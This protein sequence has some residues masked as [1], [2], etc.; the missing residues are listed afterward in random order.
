M[1]TKIKGFTLLELLVVIAIL[2]LLATMVVASTSNSRTQ[3][4]IEATRAQL[5]QIKTAILILELDTGRSAGG[6]P[7]GPVAGTGN[8]FPINLA[9]TGMV[10]L[11]VPY[12]LGVCSWNA[13]T[14]A[15]WNGPYISISPPDPWGNQYYFDSDYYPRQD[16]PPTCSNPYPAGVPY[17][18]VVSG[19]PNGVNGGTPAGGPYD[20]DDIFV[21]LD[22]S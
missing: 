20:C 6:C 22:G 9:K 13:T 11:P 16:G 1:S 3:A 18:V 4:R 8:E 2:G 21:I 14:V 15:K 12:V 19:G 5:R 7:I 17:A 10:S